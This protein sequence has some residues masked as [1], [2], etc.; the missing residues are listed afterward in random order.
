VIHVSSLEMGSC[1]VFY[2][3]YF[4]QI[5]TLLTTDYHP[6]FVLMWFMSVSHFL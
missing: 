6:P 3:I 5:T 2:A 4:H 1:F